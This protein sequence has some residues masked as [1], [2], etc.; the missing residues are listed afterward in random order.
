MSFTASSSRVL[1][2]RAIPLVAASTLSISIYAVYNYSFPLR[3]DSETPPAPSASSTS[4]LI[5]RQNAILAASPGPHTPIAWGTNRYLTLS[6]DQSTTVLKKPTP[7]SRLGS[8]PYR[9]I[10]LAEQYGACVDANG[11]LWMWGAGYDPSGEMG[12]SLKGKLIALSSSGK[13]Y[14]VS[15]SKAFQDQ[16]IYKEEMSWWSWLFGSSPGVD[17][18]ELKPESSLKRGER[19][20][21]VAVGTHHLL[22]ATTKGRTF[23]LPLTPAANSHRQLGT[24]E[25]F[26]TSFPVP[27]SP[28]ALSKVSELPPESDIRFATRLKEIHLLKGINVAQ[29]AASDRTSFMRTSNGKV[30]GFGAN[31]AGQIGLGTGGTIEIIQVPVEIVLAKNYPSGTSVECIDVVAA[32]QSTFF[33]VRRA[34]PGS[35]TLIDLLSCGN[36]MSGSLGNGLWSS[37]GFAPVK[38]KTVS[39]LQEYSEKTKSFV[40]VEIHSISAA[41]SSAAHVFAVLD[42]VA[43]A[44]KDGLQKGLYGRDVMVWGGN[45]DYQLG[46]GKR[47]S[48][49]VPQHLLPIIPRL[50][51]GT[52]A[53]TAESGLS[54]GTLSPMPHSR[55]Q[56]HDG[57]A[58]AYDPEGKLLKRNVKYEETVVAGWNA[59]VLYNKIKL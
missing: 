30:L 48:L 28:Q 44:D 38:V 43:Q 52:A 2:S 39:G 27:S 51:S 41:P 25:E 46:N 11:D 14:A 8:T 34:T 5:K 23:S 49:A 7:L 57:K 1:R 15:A 12:K 26:S 58:N 22:A 54:S 21:S 59:S 55:L 33:T 53:V 9:D 47:S 56:L 31:E 29:V 6:S 16:K 20:K 17:F 42:T 4:A 24:N 10:V 50:L 32:G 37:A 13:L 45:G 18:I 40:P 35:S 19:W 3:A 36:G